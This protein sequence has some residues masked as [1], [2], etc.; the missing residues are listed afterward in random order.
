[1]TQYGQQAAFL[2]SMQRGEN[3]EMLFLLRKKSQVVAAKNEKED[4]RNTDTSRVKAAN[5]TAG[6]IFFSI[7]RLLFSLSII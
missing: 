3:E 2:S 5:T 7:L 6:I 1:M 4:Y